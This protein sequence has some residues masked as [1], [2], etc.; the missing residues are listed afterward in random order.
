MERPLPISLYQEKA[1]RKSEEHGNTGT[2]AS[3]P[4]R[5]IGGKEERG[6]RYK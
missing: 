5:G 3:I 1:E 4:L 2:S 6:T